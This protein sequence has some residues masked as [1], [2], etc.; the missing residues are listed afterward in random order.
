MLNCIAI[1]NENHY[2]KLLEDYCSRM[3]IVNLMFSFAKPQ[4]AIYLFKSEKID[5][6]FLDFEE[7]L[8]YMPDFFLHMPKEVKIILFTTELSNSFD[9]GQ[10]PVKEVIFRPY[11]FERL[12]EVIIPMM[13]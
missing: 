9:W 8:M 6:V 7:G 3:S 13:N 4:N 11:R 1:G 10:M 12:L 2:Q 5:V